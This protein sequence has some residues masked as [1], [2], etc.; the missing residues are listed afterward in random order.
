MCRATTAAVLKTTQN[1]CLLP[2]ERKLFILQPGGNFVRC[3][4]TAVKLDLSH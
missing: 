1:K 3:F 4:Y 2:A